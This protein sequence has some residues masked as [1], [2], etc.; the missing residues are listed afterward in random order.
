MDKKENR[1]VYLDII[2]ILAAILVVFIHTGDFL[3]FNNNSANSTVF[4]ILFS[5]CRIGIPLFLM[6]TGAL[7]LSKEYS[8][9]KTFKIILKYWII[10]MIVSLL[11]YLYFNGWS[12]QN[13]TFVEY[14]R[15]LFSESHSIVTWYL[16][17]LIG[18]Y[19]FVPILQ[20]VVKTLNDKDLLYTIII[21]LLLPTLLET[22]KKIFGFE[23]NNIYLLS[24]ISLYIGIVLTGYYV[25][26]IKLDGKIFLMF[27]SVFL[28]ST[29][30][31][32]ISIYIPSLTYGDVSRLLDYPTS[33]LVIISSISFFYSIR[34]LFDEKELSTKKKSIIKY[35]ASTTLGT[36]LVHPFFHYKFY[37]ML[38]S[39]IEN[40]ILHFLVVTLIVYFLS[41][42][43]TMILKLI[44]I[45]K[46]YI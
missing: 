41:L 3:L 44:P 30:L 29:L 5:F 34:Y 39:H 11:H 19:F 26:K 10:L 43:I 7:T 25:S 31:L 23:Y 8:Y 22:C 38:E 4:S 27:C 17:L 37:Y 12:F 32:F 28:I 16:Y 36:Y 2:K 18:I 9:K 33:F 45:V 14:F 24:P 13:L 15:K 42:F 35:F 6:V 20:R 21:C 1:I 40:D 46:K